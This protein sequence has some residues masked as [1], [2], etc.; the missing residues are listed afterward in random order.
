[1]TD[2][3]KNTR[4]K[5]LTP[6]P[7]SRKGSQDSMNSIWHLTVSLSKIKKVEKENFASPRLP[8]RHTCNKHGQESIVSAF[9]S[10]FDVLSCYFERQKAGR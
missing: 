9:A 4:S 10:P 7:G 3:G 6:A 8:L 2:T 5:Q 1:M